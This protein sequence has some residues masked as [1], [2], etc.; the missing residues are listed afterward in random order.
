MRREFEDKI[1][2]NFKDASRKKLKRLCYDI[3][4]KLS[5]SKELD[6]LLRLDDIII[7]DSTRD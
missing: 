7:V 3:F 4:I 6:I 5:K 2:K 1:R